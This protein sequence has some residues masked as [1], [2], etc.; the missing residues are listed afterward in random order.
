MSF[1]DQLSA[2]NFECHVVQS[3][4]HSDAHSDET[5]NLLQQAPLVPPGTPVVNALAKQRAMLENVMRACRGLMPENNM[6]SSLPNVIPLAVVHCLRW[7][8]AVK[9]ES[10]GNLSFSRCTQMLE[11]KV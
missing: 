10:L 4:A 9:P 8:S 11:F 3:D 7:S 1:C 6:V 2:S 5:C